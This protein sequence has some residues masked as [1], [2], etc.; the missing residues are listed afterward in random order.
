MSSKSLVIVF[1]FDICW[2]GVPQ[3]GRHHR[4]GPL[5][6]SLQLGFSQ[7]G[8]RQKALGAGP[9]CPG[10]MMEVETLLQALQDCVE[11]LLKTFRGDPIDL[12]AGIDAMGFILG[13]AIAH[14]LQKGFLAIRK[15]GH[16]CVKTLSKH[17][18]DYQGR[19]KV[20]EMRADAISP[21]LRVLL[22]DQWVETGGT[23]RGAIHLVEEQG[24]L[25][26]GI[27]AICVEDSEGGL[28]LKDRYKWAHCVPPQLMPQFNAHRL[29][30]FHA[31]NS[32][33][34]PQ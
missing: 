2:E 16:L 23:M 12:V 24:G 15:A 10:R 26:A 13:A 6:S 34:G 30:S 20:M 22:V 25:V 3:G 17:Y 11:D 32:N 1:L 29:D 21:G 5:P 33:Q 4:E 8:N 27:A 19:E 28:W 14:T 31:F 7:R 18:K 9:Q